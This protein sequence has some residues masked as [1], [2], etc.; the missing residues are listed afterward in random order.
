[1]GATAV[2]AAD[3]AASSVWSSSPAAAAATLGFFAGDAFFSG[4]FF[5]DLPSGD[6]FGD[7]FSADFGLVSLTVSRSGVLLARADRRTPGAA[8]DSVVCVLLA[9]SSGCAA[10]LSVV[11]VAVVASGFSMG[12]ARAVANVGPRSDFRKMSDPG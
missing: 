8:A 7:F 9:A 1:M 11:I 3:A 6:F 12:G 2:E 4:D 10:E 5:G